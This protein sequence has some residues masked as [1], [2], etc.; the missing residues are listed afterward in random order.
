MK[1]K[2]IFSFTDKNQIWRL[3]ISSSAK[4]IIETRDTVK[5]E[6]FFH[7]IDLLGGKKILTGYQ[8]EEKFWV[9]IEAVHNDI[10]YFHMFARPNMPEH[11]K[12]FAFDI[13]QSKIL[14]INEE[15]TFLA[16]L[17]D[18]LFASRKIFDGQ[19]IFVLDYKSGEIIEE[20]GNDPAK[21]NSIL[22]TARISE[23]YSDYHY[24]SSWDGSESTDISAI[25]SKEIFNKT[26]AEN[27]EILEYKDLLLFNYYVRT[28]ENLLDNH[29]AVYNI[30]KKKKLF[31]DIINKDLNSFSPDSFFCYKNYL[32]LLKNKKEIVS[33]I[34]K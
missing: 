2:K 15:L 6:V 13:D 21:L 26:K 28:R 19:D 14:W 20:L 12:I 11:K 10:L 5:K 23:D 25:L 32:I 16:L 3:L 9:G 17:N 27:I 22:E 30:A 34:I 7:I 31:S 1:I 29:F 33:Y 4:L 18:R 24:P 8:L